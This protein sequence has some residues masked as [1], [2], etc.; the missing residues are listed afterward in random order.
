H[1]CR[2]TRVACRAADHRVPRGR[3]PARTDTGAGALR[4]PGRRGR[5][6]PG[7]A[8]PGGGTVTDVIRM[9]AAEVA[10]KIHAGELSA[11]EVTQAHLDRIAKVDDQIKAFLHVDR[12]EEHTSE[13][14]S[15]E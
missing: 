6:L 10:A 8:D 3:G 5:S 7:A 13:L 1:R 4:C 9:T 2:A 15:R 14:Q 11:V 12:S